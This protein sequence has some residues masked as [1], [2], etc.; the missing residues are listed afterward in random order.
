MQVTI[1][2]V[3]LPGL[4]CVT[5]GG[6]YE[7]VHVGLQSRRDVVELIAG[8]AT[9]AVWSFAVEVID[10]A[11]G[12]DFRGPH[13]Q[14]KRGDRFV[15]LSWGE[16]KADGTFAMFRRAKLMLNRI[17]SPV[18]DEVLDS[19]IALVGTL[20][21]TGRD[22]GPLCAAVKPDVVTW[23]AGHRGQPLDEAR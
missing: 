13:V 3:D 20:R 16:V 19:E 9:R 5:T 11:D 10:Q 14:G 12:R 22:G 2:G 4:S 6:R 8:N 7:N 15:Y 23:T 21:L 17:D 1:V 18:I